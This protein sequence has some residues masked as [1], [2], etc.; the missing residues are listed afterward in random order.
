MRVTLY[1]KNGQQ[2]DF[3]TA[4]LKVNDKAK[5]TGTIKTLEYN[6]KDKG[7]S[8]AYV[9]LDEIIAI[10]RDTRKDEDY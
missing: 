3:E 2:I 6:M 9:N 10:T 7:M 4:T 5:T 1:M 8:L